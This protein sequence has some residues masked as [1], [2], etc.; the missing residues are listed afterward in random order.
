MRRWIVLAAAFAAILLAASLTA[1]RLLVPHPTPLPLPGDLVDAASP[2]G[3]Q[4]LDD[5][6]ATADYGPLIRHFEP[7]IFTSYCGVASSVTVLTALGLEVS[8]GE[9]FTEPAERVRSRW[10]VLLGGMSLDALADLIEAHGAEATVHHADSFAPID[11]RGAVTAN[12]SRPGDYLI[13]N[14]ERAVLGERPGGHISPIAAYDRESDRVLVLDTAAHVYPP[15][16]IPLDQL[17]AAM[18]T[19]DP[20]TNAFRGYVEVTEAP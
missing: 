9:F 13:V 4:L 14:Y 12:L 19:I 16:W 6:E 8:Q 7:Q 10:R 20:T 17:D 5:A 11:F 3:R 18:G 1:W 15:T 2:S